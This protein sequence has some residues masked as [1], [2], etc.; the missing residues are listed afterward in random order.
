MQSVTNSYNDMEVLYVLVYLSWV[1]LVGNAGRNR[2]CGT[3]RAVVVALLLSPV[4]GSWYVLSSERVS[5]ARVKA[6]LY[7]KF[8]L[9]AESLKDQERKEG[10]IRSPVFRDPEEP[11]RRP[12]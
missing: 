12:R 10:D 1:V 5:S 3:T 6:M 7:H 11:A 8:K 2:L 9:E 4:V